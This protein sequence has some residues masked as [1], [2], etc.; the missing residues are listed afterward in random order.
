MSFEF[1]KYEVSDRIAMVTLDRP[2]AANGLNLGLAQELAKVAKQLAENATVKA[3]ILTASGRFFC[4]G[5]DVKAMHDAQEGMAGKTVREIADA[6]HEAIEFFAN[7]RAPLICAVNGTAAGAGFSISVMGDMA[8]ASESAKFTMAYSNI[9]LSPDGSSSF[10]LPRLIGLRKTQ[11]LMYT[12]RVLSAQEAK[13]W[14]LLNEVVADNELMPRAKKIAQKFVIGSLNSNAS[15]KKL[16]RQSGFNSL[17]Q[18]LELESDTIEECADGADGKE[19]V[20]SF[21]EKRKPNF[22]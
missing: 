7:M 13:E 15:I 6:L 8:I 14:G 17:H 9:G 20:T 16:L 11:E 10:Y 3:V 18:Q 22:Q 2:E 5:G 12:N 1:L 4:A 21:V 19:G